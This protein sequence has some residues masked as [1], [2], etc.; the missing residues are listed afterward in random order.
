M[1]VIACG[2]S[3]F[4]APLVI[5]FGI[6]ALAY[7]TPFEW[8]LPFSQKQETCFIYAAFMTYRCNIRALFVPRMSVNQ[9]QE[10]LKEKNRA[11][12]NIKK[13]EFV[14]DMV[15]GNYA[16]VSLRH[17]RFTYRVYLSKDLSK[18]AMLKLQDYNIWSFESYRC[19]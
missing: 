16:E 7:F 14:D 8:I 3:K 9:F 2:N 1:P 5:A 10:L 13:V 19:I 18:G 12:E 15:L 4:I 17:S 6:L 11:C